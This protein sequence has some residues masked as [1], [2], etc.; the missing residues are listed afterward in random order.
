MPR[1]GPATLNTP[2]YW[3]GVYLR[4][5]YP[6][7][8]INNMRRYEVAASMQLG[9]SALDIGCGQAGLGRIL[10][11]S[12]PRNFFYRGCDFSDEALRLHVL[13]EN[14][15]DRWELIQCSWDEIAL[16]GWAETVYL[17]D[18]LEH[19][20]DPSKLLLQAAQ[21]ARSRIVLTVPRYGALSFGQHRGEH[22]WDF[23]LDELIELASP[24]GN[25]SQPLVAGNLCWAMSIPLRER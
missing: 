9:A 10:L 7:L 22:A 21:A 5:E 25:L 11:A 4:N 16:H 23:T 19:V 14:L 12:Q 1:I 2:E 15:Q 24:H 3:D 6:T 18:V 8:D 20:A 13:P 17:C